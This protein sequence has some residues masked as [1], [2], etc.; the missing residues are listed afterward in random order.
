VRIS[1]LRHNAG[2]WFR[3][4]RNASSCSSECMARAAG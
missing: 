3:A 4:D 1:M 2:A